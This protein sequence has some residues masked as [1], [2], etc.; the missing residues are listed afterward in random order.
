VIYF[1]PLSTKVEWD[2]FKERTHVIRCE[3]TQGIVAYNDAGDLMGVLVADSFS[4][5]SCNV[6][7]AIDNPIVIK[8]G[9]LNEIG[10][11]LFNVCKRSHIFGL[12]PSNNKRAIKFDKHIGFTEVARIPDGVGTGTD[13]VIL[14]MDRVDC[15]WIAHE[16]EQEV[17]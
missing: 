13:Y 11:H 2:W 7:M 14:R 8:Y 5:D 15:P 6:H 4:P 3:D 16:E 10:N 17:A 1:K 9:F 12:V